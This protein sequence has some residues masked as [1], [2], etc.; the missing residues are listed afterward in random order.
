MSMTRLI[1]ASLAHHWRMNTAVALGV[2]VAVAVLIGALLVGDSMRGSLRKL[3]LDRL[4]RIDH[5]LVADRFF[6]EQLA[7]ELAISD[8]FT[9]Q[10]GEAVPV[11]LLR[12]TLTNPADPQQ[13]IRANRVNLI[14]CDER[15][16]QL[17]NAEV[18]RIDRDVA[19]LG[20][21]AVAPRQLS[22]LPH[23]RR[24]V[25]N[26]PLAEQLGVDVDDAV[27]VRLARVGT[28]PAESP[29]GRPPQAI[30][31]LR[32][33]VGAI[34]EPQGLGAF[35]L[36]P[37]QQSPHNAY[38]A[39]DTLQQRLDRPSQV[40]A[41]L[42]AGRQTDDV[43]TRDAQQR[44][45]AMLRPRLSDYGL[46]VTRWP[47]GFFTLSTDRMLFSRSAEAAVE[48]A[49]KEIRPDRPLQP[50]LTYLA[51]TIACGRREIP[52]S[53]ITAVDLSVRPPLGPL[54]DTDGKPVGPLG[55]NEIV[56]NGWAAE[57]LH[58]QLGD[59]IRVSYFEPESLHGQVRQRT[60]PFKLAAIVPLAGAAADRGFLP[61]VPGVTDRMT[62]DD[63]DPPFPFDA[64]RIR[65]KDED[66]WQRYRGTP[67]AFVSLGT[68][69]RLWVG[70]FGRT[71]TIRVADTP[72]GTVPF[73]PARR[74]FTQPVDVAA[75]KRG[76]SPSVL[77]APL[78][79]P[80]VAP[81]GAALADRLPAHE[82]GFVFRPIKRQSLA[83][84]AGTTSFNLLFLGFSF[85][86]IVSAVLL[87]VLLFRLGV[88]RRAKQIG[89]L[90]AVGW[91]PRRIAR[92]LAAEGAVVAL[93]GSVLGIGLGIGYAA[94][95]LLGL[96]TWWLAAIVTP[97]LRLHAS[98]ASLAVGPAV[99]F[100]VSLAV[101]ALSVRRVGRASPRRLMAGRSAE[102]PPDRPPRRHRLGPLGLVFIVLVSAA[103][104][105]VLSARLGDEFQAGAF[106]GIG[107]LVLVGLVT[108]VGWQ[109]ATGNR[110]AAIRAGRGNL[111]RLAVLGAARHPSRSTLSVALVAAAC[112]LIVSV[113]AFR[114]DPRDLRAGRDSP[115]GR[116][117]LVGRSDLPIYE[118]LAAA[119]GRRA[120]GFPERDDQQL[121][122]CTIISFRVKPGDDASCLN[123]YQPRQP[124]LLGVPEAMITR[125]GFAWAAAVDQEHPWRALVEKEPSDGPVPMVLERD[126][127]TYS[128]HL[129]GGLGATYAI[130][131]DSG[132]P[133]PLQVVGQL[134]GSPFQGD[135]LISE[136]ELLGLFPEV[137]GYRFFLIECPVEQI[138]EVRA[139]LERTL[140]DYGFA[141]VPMTDYLAGF[142][143]VP[144]TYLS[145]FQ[146]LGGLGLLLGTFGLAVVQFRNVIE[147][148]HELALLRAVGLGRRQIAW[149]VMAEN[150]LLLVAGLV[151]GVLAATVAVL[152][153][154]LSGDASIPW[155]SLGSTLALILLIGL[156]AGLL[157]V[158]AAV[159][160]PILEA[161][162]EE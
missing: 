123:L 27:T 8:G 9:D 125:G 10:F 57:D 119:E 131:D 127:A 52:Y 120:L 13:P 72:V 86:I 12:G 28:I 30:Q 38:I 147:R 122:D 149:L 53:T 105:T 103:A 108:G 83:A 145:T 62:I 135:L 44:L 161:L 40:N 96:Q 151:C 64:E 101:I 84:S 92:W 23:G 81:L 65:Q 3:A 153:H 112:F 39:L 137:T 159:A 98:G 1:L 146:S 109:L 76:L 141:A 82:M 157:A 115:T 99:G 150:G 155:A 36:N 21:P 60:T 74:S 154:L 35:G 54:L 93:L 22:K 41:I 26:R 17:G 116:F 31:S 134:R 78:D 121:S 77:S 162:R 66:Y 128:L 79:K 143:A 88:E 61:R 138:A 75:A 97:F 132:R 136:K 34:V 16:W 140:G 110:A 29:L 102:P 104:L 106:F 126:T 55:D 91:P 56:L 129:K 20:K 158:R 89:M 144:N 85:F 152:P 6:R 94:L 114:V 24:I 71:T 148:R 80:A 51:N 130:D 11:I 87:V 113:S 58:A 33:R 32:L 69:R 4:G 95:M 70:R 156:A 117:T 2:A 46:R 59:T 37:S 18:D 107:A 5:V 43:P 160:A 48:E 111:L 15:F 67:K 14:G 50:A 63:W 73:L 47:R 25:L 139:A 45:Q 7:D 142:L 49:L 68:G 133:V 100:A 19:L 118:N 42:V 124:R 90:L